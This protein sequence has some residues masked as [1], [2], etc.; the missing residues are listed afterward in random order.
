MNPWQ[1]DQV[2]DVTKSPG[3]ISMVQDTFLYY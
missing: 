3:Y 1:G 2:S